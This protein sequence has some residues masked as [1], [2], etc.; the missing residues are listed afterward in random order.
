MSF[1]LHHVS[2]D[3]WIMYLELP[4]NPTIYFRE[5]AQAEFKIG[6]DSAPTAL[7]VQY[8]HSKAEG[9]KG[10]NKVLFSKIE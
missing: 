7:Q 6:V 1:D 9:S 10:S 2:G 4:Q 5:Y 3:W 8:D